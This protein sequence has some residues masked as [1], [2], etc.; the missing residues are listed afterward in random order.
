[1]ANCSRFS[2]R[3]PIGLI[4]NFE[5]RISSLDD[6]RA[7]VVGG[8]D[9][10]SH[11]RRGG[12]RKHGA[13]DF[14]RGAKADGA[15]GGAGAAQERAK[16]A[17]GFSGGDYFIEKRDEFLAERLVKMIGEGAA[18]RLIFAGGKSGGDGAGVSGILDRLE[19]IDA[20]WKEAACF[21]RR[22]FEIGDEKDEMQLGGDG[23]HPGLE[24]ADNVESPIARGRGIVWVPF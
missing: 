13:G 21:G 22:D 10:G 16:G 11:A 24:A 5:F 3:W 20:R 4:S 18:Q 12:G 2:V 6:T 9:E 23:K 15:N 14:F 19:T 7:A 8:G 1:M 17:G